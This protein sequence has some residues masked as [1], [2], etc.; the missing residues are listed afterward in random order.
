MNGLLRSMNGH[1]K[2]LVYYQQPSRGFEAGIDAAI[3]QPFVTEGVDFKQMVREEL[4]KM[5]DE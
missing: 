3:A 2:S 1:L 5:G 4:K